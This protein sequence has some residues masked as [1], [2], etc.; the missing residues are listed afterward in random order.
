MQRSL[1]AEGHAER[2]K[3]YVEQCLDKWECIVSDPQI[4]ATMSRSLGLPA[5]HTWVEVLGLEPELLELVDSPCAAMVLLY[6][7][8]SRSILDFK[9]TR[10]HRQSHA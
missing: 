7:S 9:A 6:P 8:Q 2:F 5:S 4:F 10:P 3:A 1:E